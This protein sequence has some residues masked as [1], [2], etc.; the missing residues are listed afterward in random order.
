M[1][2]PSLEPAG[3]VLLALQRATH[4]TLRALSS[5]VSELGLTPG[6][7]NAIANLRLDGSMTVS[8]LAAETGSQPSTTTSVLDRLEQR[9]LVSRGARPGDR[10]AV[11]VGLTPA[12]RS[13]ARRVS[14][15][16]RDLEREALDGLS[17][18]RVTGLLLGL[19]A[20]SQVSA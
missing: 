2:S 13:A 6:E 3:S 5:R 15:A 11:L 7:I 1:I 4:V 18:A 14:T 10:R 12:G 16:V 9:G 19:Q 17:A 20:L 8:E